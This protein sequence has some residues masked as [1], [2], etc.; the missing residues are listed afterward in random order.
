MRSHAIV[1]LALMFSSAAAVKSEELVCD[2]TYNEEI[3]YDTLSTPRSINYFTIPVTYYDYHVDGSNPDFGYRVTSRW[4]QTGLSYA[5]YSGWVD[6]LLSSDGKLPQ[7]APALT[8]TFLDVS[9]NIGKLFK[10]WTAGTLD[11]FVLK[12]PPVIE[13]RFVDTVIVTLDTTYDIDSNMTITADTATS[14][15]VYDTIKV[16]DTT[17]ISDTMFKNIVIND[18]LF[19][20]WLPNELT[21]DD[22]TDSMW[23]FGKRQKMDPIN[24]KGFGNESDSTQNA[25]Y[26]FCVRNKFT[27]KQGEKIH[28]GADDDAYLFI[29]GKLVIECGGFHE[30]IPVILDLDSFSLAS[31]TPLTVGQKYDLDI[32]FVERRMGGNWFIAGLSEFENKSAMQVDTVHDTLITY[33]IVKTDIDT[34][35]CRIGIDP[36]SRKNIF[37]N[38]TLS[39][40]NIPV[41]AEYVAFEYFSISGAKVMDKK[42]LVKQALA[43]K[44]A[45]LPCGMY[46]VRINFMN[47]QGKALSKPFFR[48]MLV[49]R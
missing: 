13:T 25:G 14:L 37:Q 2:T 38:Q 21:Y 3:V 28:F 30:A 47:G 33:R 45:S 22:T 27:Y 23:T 4:D 9:W 6:S 49:K 46:V 5:N 24:G 44:S 31:A 12:F 17:M 26:T 11:T 29:N 35:V 8:D 20:Y 41:S 36:R 39:G 42:M 19:A 10:P 34:I 48:K 18:S 7:R 16:A 15:T 43:D 40:L 32:F 1:G